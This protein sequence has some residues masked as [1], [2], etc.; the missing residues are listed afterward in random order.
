SALLLTREG[1]LATGITERRLQQLVHEEVWVRVHRGQYVDGA[2]WRELWPE[3]RQLLRVIAFARSS[4][5][6][7][8]IF[9]HLSAAVLWGLPLY[10]LNAEVVH[11]LIAGARHSRRSA[12]VMRH[13]LAVHDLDIVERHGLR[14]TSLTRTVAD[15]ARTFPAE[16]AL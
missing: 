15:L 2:T 10:R 5:G 12:G 14:C 4:P 3:G 9:T 11:V 8:P 1:V 16:V 6:G 7:A 13:D